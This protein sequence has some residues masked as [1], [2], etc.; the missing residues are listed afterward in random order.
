MFTSYAD[1]LPD[2]VFK[3]DEAGATSSTG[4]AGPGFAKVKFTSSNQ[5]QV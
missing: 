1:T 2:P 3:T 5:T 4:N